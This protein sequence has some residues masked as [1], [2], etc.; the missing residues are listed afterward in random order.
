MM[1]TRLKM[2]NLVPCQYVDERSSVQR[3]ND[4]YGRMHVS[5]TNEASGSIQA[6]ALEADKVYIQ[7]PVTIL[8]D[9]ADTRSGASTPSASQAQDN[10]ERQR[11]LAEKQMKRED[12][13]RR[14]RENAE[15]KERERSERLHLQQDGGHPG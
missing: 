3:V 12:Q 11:L 14:T 5:L 10:G 4:G 15:R 2:G 9:S 6:R 13:E 8:L 7:G 1:Q